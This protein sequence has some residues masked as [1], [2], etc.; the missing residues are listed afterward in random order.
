MFKIQNYQRR[1]SFSPSYISSTR[2][3]KQQWVHLKFKMA[4]VIQSSAGQ[5]H[6][7]AVEVK[8]CQKWETMENKKEP[9]TLNRVMKC[10]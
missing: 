4:S 8:A 5:S 1:Q 7:M 3:I 2:L 6:Q 10:C 9:E